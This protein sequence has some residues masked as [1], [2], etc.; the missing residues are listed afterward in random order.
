MNP[1]LQ[2]YT[3]ISG[4]PCITLTYLSGIPWYTGGNFL[5]SMNSRISI[6]SQASCNF[7]DNLLFVTGAYKLRKYHNLNKLAF[8]FNTCY[9]LPGLLLCT[10]YHFNNIQYTW[11]TIWY[12]K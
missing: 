3:S 8:R 1:S 9:C 5:E 10:T 4:I 2:Q 7:T 11:Y 12:M 6:P